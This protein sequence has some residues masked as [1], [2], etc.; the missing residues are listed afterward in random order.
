MHELYHVDQNG[1]WFLVPPTPESSQKCHLMLI[2]SKGFSVFISYLI[3]V[4]LPIVY[5]KILE[6]IVDPLQ[7]HISHDLP[8]LFM[9]LFLYFVSSAVKD[10]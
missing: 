10:C 7:N 1:R 9:N 3:D 5:C 2:L 6:N 4:H 8:F